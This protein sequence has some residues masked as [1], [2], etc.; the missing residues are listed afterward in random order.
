ME[1][2]HK[3]TTE[4][5]TRDKPGRMG[6]MNIKVSKEVKW[7]LIGLAMFVMG[8]LG[9]AVSP[10]GGASPSPLALLGFIIALGGVALGVG[11]L[12]R[13]VYLDFEPAETTAERDRRYYPE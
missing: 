7:L 10:N 8:W 12:A 1:R 2:V 3:M 6:N 11:M 13:L 4:L 5:H 9:F